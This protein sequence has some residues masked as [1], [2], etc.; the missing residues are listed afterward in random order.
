MTNVIESVSSFLDKYNLKNQ[1]LCLG[2]SGGYDSMCLL[3]VLHRLGCNVVA[4]HLNHNWRGEESR[5]EE[6]RCR[7]F[8][9]NL[10]VKFYSETLSA[11]VP[12]TETAAREERYK[13]FKRAMQKFDASAFITAHNANDNAETVIYRLARGTGVD[14]LA[15]IS[16]K[17]DYFYRPLISVKRNDIEKYCA[18]NDLSPNVDSSNSDTKYMRN[19]IRHEIMPL[20]E[21]INPDAIDAINSLSSLAREDAKIFELEKNIT[22]EKFLALPFS[23]QGRVIKVMLVEKNIDYDKERIEYL[24]NFLQNNK[25]SRSGNKCSVSDK[26][27]FFVNNKE[28]KIVDKPLKSCNEIKIDSEGCFEFG[29][30]NFIIEPCSE[31]PEKFPS[32]SDFVAYA[33]ISTIDFTLRT[34]R[35]GD[36]LYPL[37]GIGKQKFKKYLNGKKVPFY[38]KDSIV[39][40]CSGKEILW[41]AGLG[42]SDKIKVTDTVTHRFK[43]IKKGG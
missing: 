19:L 37:G 25:N 27:M 29:N 14:G 1:V 24:I 17:R 40:L 33:N 4:V 31:I 15:A 10:G 30:Y 13:F 22:T 7:N 16:P 42:I 41:A 39:L 9:E 6:F 26:F 2:F 35:D 23:I 36:Y 34:R 8:C 11:D 32:D 18:D 43:L 3:H 20:L 28:F 21:K 12:H 38:E 5:N